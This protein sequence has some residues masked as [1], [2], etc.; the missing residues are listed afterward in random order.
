MKS[1]HLLYYSVRFSRYTV[2]TD[3][4]DYFAG[5][6]V[7]TELSSLELAPSKYIKCKLN[8]CCHLFCHHRSLANQ[9]IQLGLLVD[10]CNDD[11]F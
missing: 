1:H 3:H 9:L 11:E 2:N 7:K 5:N 10:W 8:H 4:T 6:V